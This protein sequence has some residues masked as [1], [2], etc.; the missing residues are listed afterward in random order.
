[1]AQISMREAKK[2]ISF[3]EKEPFRPHQNP[4]NII[5][6]DTGGKFPPVMSGSI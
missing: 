4:S 6:Q 1:M 3:W 2:L 5:L